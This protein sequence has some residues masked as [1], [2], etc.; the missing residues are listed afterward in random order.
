MKTFTEEQL[1]NWYKPVST[2]EDE[3]I[4]H[5][6][7]MIKRAI[8]NSNDFD[9]LTYEIFVQG[10]YGN[11]TNVK[12][13]SDVD[14]N[15]MLTSTFF[16]CYP[17]GKNRDDYGFEPGAISYSEYKEMIVK[18]LQSKFGIES[19]ML[20]NKSIKITSNSYRVNADCVI[21]MQYRNY[22]DIN[23]INPNAYIE[24]IKYYAKDESEVINYPK[25]HITNGKVKNISTN[26]KY[27]KLVRIFKCIRN[28]MCNDGIITKDKITSF[29]V[30]CLV[31]NVPDKNIT[32]YTTW[33]ETVKQSI[34]YL[35]N[36]IKNNECNQWGEVSE[37]L[38]LFNSNRKWTQADAKDFLL[39]MWNYMGYDN[40]NN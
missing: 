14:V 18:A 39:K 31:W 12:L 16:A 25:D 8:K 2:T 3:K 27:K 28:K 15:I 33:N 13:D 23:S 20:G 24:G 6:I 36:G 34:I 30:E 17:N 21:S 9:S 19:I 22:R 11:N 5:T 7:D 32:K 35:Y 38:Y 29:L 40:E 4:N 10:S 37:R 26:Y 1:E